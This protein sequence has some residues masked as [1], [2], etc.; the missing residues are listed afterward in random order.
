VEHEYTCSAAFSFGEITAKVGFDGPVDQPDML[1]DRLLATIATFGSIEGLR[2]LGGP[3]NGKTTEQECVINCSFGAISMLVKVGLKLYH[4]VSNKTLNKIVMGEIMTRIWMEAAT[5][6][7]GSRPQQLSGRSVDY[8]D[9]ALGL[10]TTALQTQA[11]GSRGRQRAGNGHGNGQG[12][13]Q[14]QRQR[15]GARR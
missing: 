1:G 13:R 2:A 10:N 8:I 14:H 6:F 3:A 7:S 12:T 15:Q 11:S 4:D 5:H 9:A